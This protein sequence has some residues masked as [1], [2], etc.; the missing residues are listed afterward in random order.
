M[1]DKKFDLRLNPLSDLQVTYQVKNEQIFSGAL[2]R[3]IE[4]L[5]L[6]LILIYKSLGNIGHGV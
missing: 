6:L 4:F 1:F 3:T 2:N 5:S